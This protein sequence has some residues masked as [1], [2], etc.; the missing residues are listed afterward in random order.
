MA[1]TA[2]RRGGSA[3]FALASAALVATVATAGPAGAAAT[4]AGPAFF[5]A[6]TEGDVV[7][8]NLNLPAAVGPLPKN[9]G[10]ALISAKGNALHDA[11]GGKPDSSESVARLAGGNLVEGAGAPLNA[12]DQF[13]SAT[14]ADPLKQRNLGSLP[15]NPLAQGVLGDL[16]AQVTK[17]TL[18]NASTAQLGHATILQLGDVLPAQLLDQLRSQLSD[19]TPQTQQV[20]DDAVSQLQ[21]IVDQL[22]QNDPTGASGQ[23]SSLISDLSATLEQAAAA[24]AD[25]ARQ[26][27]VQPADQPRRGGCG[28]DHLPRR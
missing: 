24:A 19:I 6:A 22:K 13:V 26:R 4:P 5:S 23:V 3:A 21:S 9:I 14:L 15:A 2:R 17:A 1:R 12:L 11:V 18:G 7:Q 27:A 25:A 20:L 8:V 28:P 16:K 10:V